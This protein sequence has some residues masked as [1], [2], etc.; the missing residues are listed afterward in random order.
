MASSSF[1]E[2]QLRLKIS[3][4]E[5]PLNYP[6]LET[7]TAP[8]TSDNLTF[9]L[10]SYLWSCLKVRPPRLVEKW[11][12]ISLFCYYIKSTYT[13]KRNILLRNN[14]GIP[15]FGFQNESKCSHLF[16]LM[17]T[18]YET[19]FSDKY[20]SNTITDTEFSMWMH[21]LLNP[22][23][24]EKEWE[25]INLLRQ[26]NEWILSRTLAVLTSLGLKGDIFKLLHPFP[27]TNVDWKK[28]VHL[29]AV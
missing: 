28:K 9:S 24:H 2:E 12:A 8:E 16:D 17:G 25:I 3:T 11:F 14:S 7:Q 21:Y 20:S 18:S 29:N 27:W 23:K 4:L 5:T 22:L 10:C 26:F 19:R 1:D 15:S 13:Q 6:K